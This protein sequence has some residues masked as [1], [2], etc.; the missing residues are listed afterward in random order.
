MPIT[1]EPGAMTREMTLVHAAF[2][3][4]FYL[5]PE[6]VANVAAGDRERAEIVAGHIAT[7]ADGLH[8]HH[9]GED[10]EIWPR[11]LERS[12]EEVRPLVHGMEGHHERIA[13]RLNDLTKE[14]AQWRTDAGAAHRD[15]ILHTLDELLPVLLEH[16]DMEVAYV[17]PIIEKHIT[18]EEWDTLGA[19]AMASLPPE[20]VPQV[21]GLMMYEGDPVTVGELLDKMPAEVRPV[22]IE[23]A[24]KAYADYAER[25]YG[26]R[27]PPRGSSVIKRR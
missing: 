24:P 10:I 9:T 22:M 15:A 19:N 11:L 2:L 21:V 3:R 8:H 12:P 7:I 23:A 25:V 18:G 16:L 1:K 14:T 17:L 5:M 6:L 4:E 26:T 13:A 27:T 20:A